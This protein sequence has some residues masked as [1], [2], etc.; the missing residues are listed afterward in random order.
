MRAEFSNTGFSNTAGCS[1]MPSYGDA[2]DSNNW[3]SNS[4]G[5]R[6]PGPCDLESICSQGH[7]QDL[8]GHEPHSAHFSL[9]ALFH[10]PAALNFKCTLK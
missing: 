1:Q 6:V 8:S 9:L 3:A 5:S 7:L 10:L 4:C 2:K